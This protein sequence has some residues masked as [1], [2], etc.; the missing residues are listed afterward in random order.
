MVLIT[1]DLIRK[2]AEHNEMMISTLEEISLHQLDIEKIE[3]IDKW[4]RELKILYLHNNLICKIEN[5]SRLKQLNYLNLT[6]NCIETIEGLDKCE[7]LEKLDLTA[8]FIGDMRSI[9]NLRGCAFLRTLYMTGNPCVK[10]DS[11]REYIINHLPQLTQLDGDAIDRSERLKAA[12]QAELVNQA[13]IS[14]SAQYMAKRGRQKEDYMG[15]VRR[16]EI[17]TGDEFWNE[18]EEDSPES[19]IQMHHE[20]QRQKE[21]GE[22][23]KPLFEKPEYKRTIRFFNQND[24]PINVNQ[25]GLDFEIDEDTGN[26][27]TVLL[28]VPKFLDTALIDV[29]VQPKYIRVHVKDR[30]FQIVLVDEIKPDQG[31]CERSQVTGE[32]KLTLPKVK[33]NPR[34]EPLKKIEKITI[35]EEKENSKTPVNYRTIVEDNEAEIERLKA[36]RTRELRP[37][38][39]MPRDNDANFVDCDDVPSLL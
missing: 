15:R 11:Y 5:V 34:L 14:Q 37:A 22:A 1:E 6:L 12:Q 8:N 18:V 24:E 38:K 32:M 27:T 23:R 25:A 2:R 28:K 17:K 13:V 21:E 10:F 39:A 26:S 9:V 3:H 20:R 4:C 7:N 29:D 16:G 19:R 31:K 30:A 35:N 33:F 36:Q